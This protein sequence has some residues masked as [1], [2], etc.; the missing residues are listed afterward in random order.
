M[1]KLHISLLLLCFCPTRLPAQNDAGFEMLV[2]SGHS[3]G[4]TAFAFDP[5]DTLLLATG[6]RE[7]NIKIWDAKRDQLLRNLYVTGIVRSIQFHPGNSD[8]LLVESMRNDS[9]TLQ[10]FDWPQYRMLHRLVRVL[11]G[12]LISTFLHWNKDNGLIQR[13]TDGYNFNIETL[14]TLLIQRAISPMFK[15]ADHGSVRCMASANEAQR[16]ALGYNMGDGIEVID[17]QTFKCQRLAIPDT[18][19]L[20]NI[21]FSAHSKYLYA[22][23]SRLSKKNDWSAVGYGFFVWELKPGG[24][25]LIRTGPDF[26]NE[27][28]GL[29]VSEKR[30]EVYLSGN[31]KMKAEWAKDQPSGAGIY[32]ISLQRD[33][34]P[35][36]ISAANEQCT[37]RLHPSEDKLLI[38]EEYKKLSWVNLENGAVTS[39]FPKPNQWFGDAFFQPELPQLCLATDEFGFDIRTWMPFGIRNDYQKYESPPVQHH[40]LVVKNVNTS[41]LDKWCFAFF[42]ALKHSRIPLDTICVPGNA[43]AYIWSPALNYLLVPQVWPASNK[44]NLLLYKLT[45]EAEQGR[46]KHVSLSDPKTFYVE[47]GWRIKE[48]QLS[49]DGGKLLVSS[50]KTVKN[51]GLAFDKDIYRVQAFDPQSGK[52]RWKSDCNFQSGMGMGLSFFYSKN[53]LVHPEPDS[54]IYDSL[55]NFRGKLYPA[56]IL[57]LNSGQKLQTLYLPNYT[58]YWKMDTSENILVA[59]SPRSVL[60]YNWKEGRLLREIKPRAKDI[61]A[62]SL[63]PN[64]SI[65]AITCADLVEIWHYGRGEHLLSLEITP[66][67][68]I[69]FSPEGW[70]MVPDQN[71]ANLLSFRSGKTVKPATQ[72]DLTFNR[73]DKILAK[74]GFASPA[75]VDSYFEA[76]KKRLEKSGIDPGKPLPDTKAPALSITNQQELD[77]MPAGRNVTLQ[78]NL[79]A[80]AMLLQGFNVWINNKPL[81]GLN[82]HILTADQKNGTRISFPVELISGKNNIES[83]VWD[84]S[85][86]QS[87]VAS[88]EFL[89]NTPDTPNLYVVLIGASKFKNMPPLNGP[90]YDMKSM[91][92]LFR[93]QKYMERENT[94]KRFFKHTEVIRFQDKS[95]RL[96]SLRMLQS[97]LA[98]ARPQ[99]FLFFY[100]AGHGLLKNDRFY[101][102]TWDMD[103]KNPETRGFAYDS[104]MVWTT[105]C[106]ARQQLIL[107]NACQAGENDADLARFHL[108]QRIFPDIRRNSGATVIAASSVEQS[109]FGGSGET[110]GMTVF[111]F[112][113]ASFMSNLPPY[114]LPPMDDDHMVIIKHF[115]QYNFYPSGPVRDL[116][117]DNLLSVSEAAGYIVRAVSSLTDGEQTPELRQFNPRADFPVWRTDWLSGWFMPDMLYMDWIEAHPST[118]N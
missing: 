37:I 25:E 65:I 103:F 101:L 78:L 13:L 10:L 96:D 87:E 104:L 16:A 41:S 100:Y 109:A 40:G 14:D 114:K 67:G 54:F 23:F 115:A 69:I 2:Q 24:Y 4:I 90:D 11:N 66:D 12:H 20:E 33:S 89:C 47:K 26:Q 110:A 98:K 53:Y 46:V 76:W 59:A 51:T 32:C 85:G 52:L 63:Y 91:D 79:Q 28:K 42:R 71:A 73:P 31:V 112:A 62:I 107:L 113:V 6:D 83:Q 70:Y 88:I 97:M 72:F 8:I 15:V 1:K 108:M 92:E 19:Q 82:G 44:N 29:A 75:L 77:Y 34:K 99:D 50:Y 39:G 64:D 80:G 58:W 111:G 95:V 49:L 74:T 116:N 55:I 86:R 48:A 45:E 38:L 30:N 60:F 68:P 61:R 93:F 3:S 18:V 106:A 22:H 27:L 5:I 118:K 105:D 7:G 94:S 35:K 84:E 102:S 36:R 81:A 57:D 56:R 43:W 117:K 21:Y 9:I 17:L